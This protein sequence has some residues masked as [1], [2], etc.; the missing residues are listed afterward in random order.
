MKI[1]CIYIIKSK[2]KPEKFYIGSAVDFIK[3]ISIHKHFL[4]HRKHHSPI[5]QHHVNK[6]GLTDLSF[7]II[8][9]VADTNNLLKR[10]QFYLDNWQPCFNVCKK[11][12][13]TSGR[14][15]SD[16]TK[17]KISDNLKLN[18]AKNGSIHTGMKRTDETKKKISKNRRNYSGENHPLFG[19]K[20]SEETKAKLR[21]ANLGKKHSPETLLKYKSRKVYAGEESLIGVSVRDM[22]TG[23]IY[24]T[25]GL[26]AAATGL[27]YS[28]LYNQ[29]CNI[30]TNRTTLIF[31]NGR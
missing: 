16:E 26:A 20:R 7:E 29:L 17:A 8:E 31:N 13:N 2:V 30:N 5:M 6:Y 19:K 23:V 18:F 27:K 9:K 12:G 15:V 22:K 24:K 4:K 25:V 21:E 10:E 11:A 3:R 1:S 28:T 14:V